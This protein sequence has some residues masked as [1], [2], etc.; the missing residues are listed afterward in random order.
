VKI[1]FLDFDGVLNSHEFA[2]SDRYV[3]K[4]GIFGLD[5][6]AV[7]RLN[8]ITNRPDVQ[9]VVSSYWRLGRTVEQLRDILTEVGFV[10]I[11]RDKTRDWMRR[12]D[13]NVYAAEERGHEIQAWLDEHVKSSDE[14]LDAF[15]ILDD[16][17]D[18][19]HLGSRLIQTDFELGL[20]DHH[21][22]RAIEML[23]LS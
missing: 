2:R 6:R 16:N 7:A 22:E 20:Q 17:S 4:D 12:L 9:V 10:G 14:E 5:P 8:R 21:V 18:M 11:V 13:G 23:G 19:A 15:V 1:V 3:E